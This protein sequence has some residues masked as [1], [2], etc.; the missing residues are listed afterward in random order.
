[1]PLYLVCLWRLSCVW[2]YIYGRAWSFMLLCQN[3]ESGAAWAAGEKPP[4][5]KYYRECHLG[6]WLTEGFFFVWIEYIRSEIQRNCSLSAHFSGNVP[7]ELPALSLDIFCAWI[8]AEWD[9]AS[10]PQSAAVS[11]PRTEHEGGLLCCVPFK[12]DSPCVSVLNSRISLLMGGCGS[13]WEGGLEADLNGTFC[14]RENTSV[15]QLFI[16][17]TLVEGGADGRQ[18]VRSSIKANP[19]SLGA[20]P[21]SPVTPRGCIQGS[22]ENKVPVEY[23]M[24]LLYCCSDEGG[25]YYRMCIIV[26]CAFLPSPHCV[27]RHISNIICWI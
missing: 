1:M 24:A 15:H 26:V 20:T 18:E 21:G 22:T 6:A 19:A 25:F 16:T 11:F 12:N 3:E 10:F 4:F 23:E 13:I 8:G 2:S 27:L 14:A 9:R 5:L 7:E 17:R